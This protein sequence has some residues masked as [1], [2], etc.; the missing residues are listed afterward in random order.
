MQSLGAGVAELDRKLK[1]RLVGLVVLLTIAIVILPMILGGP[2]DEG[3][4]VRLER[5]PSDDEGLPVTRLDLREPE[6]SR[7]PREEAPREESVDTGSAGDTDVEPPVTRGLEEAADDDSEASD[8][9]TEPEEADPSDAA[10][11]AET[12]PETDAE[13][14]AEPD[15][16]PEPESSSESDAEEESAAETDGEPFASAPAGSGWAVQVGSFSSRENADRLVAQ[17]RENGFQAFLMRHRHEG[18]VLYRV[19]VGLEP[20]RESAE[21]IAERIRNTTE[22][23]ARPVPHP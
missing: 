3:R 4:S 13:S 15:A 11:E 9:E 6:D 5:P 10:A 18:D 19:R 2:D 16:S 12:E 23:P 7:P 8:A 20:D 1:E 14:P 22:H 17:L 21:R